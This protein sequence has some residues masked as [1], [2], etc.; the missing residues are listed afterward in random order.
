MK[1]LHLLLIFA[2]FLVGCSSTPTPQA[3]QPTVAPVT[4]A[5]TATV[6]EPSA[7]AVPENTA[8]NTPDP[9]Q[10]EQESI[11][12]LV[13]PCNFAAKPVY[14]SPQNKW[15]VVACQ[16]DQPEDGL[17]TKFVSSDGSKQWSISFNEAY[18]KPYRAN[19]PQLGTLLEN[20]FIPVRWTKNEDFVYLAIKTATHENPFVGYDGLFRLDLSSGMLRAVL[21]P[22]TA[23][24]FATYDFKFSPN[25]T[26]LAYIN[27][28][29]QPIA[30][31][32]VDTVA[33]NEQKITLDARFTQGGSLLWSPDEKQLVVSALDG[34][35]NDT[36]SVILYNLET[37]SNEYLLQQSVDIYLPVEWAQIAGVIHAEVYP[38]KWVYIDTTTHI[39]TDAPAP[40]PAS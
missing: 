37:Q 23:P 31:T 19:D 22:A 4:V 29:I 5:A 16:G 30:I 3:A 17:T 40:S 26:K 28:S 2:L 10:Q 35:L 12:S 8:T 11:A 27:Q 38:G 1:H 13:A 7:T 33:G 39:I 18:L 14:H 15:V 20:S 32:I 6:V 21:K 24:M 34:S 9:R 36:D 25:G